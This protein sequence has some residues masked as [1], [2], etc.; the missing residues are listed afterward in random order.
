MGLEL[1]GKEIELRRAALDQQDLGGPA[2]GG[3]PEPGQAQDAHRQVVGRHPEGRGPDHR[4]LQEGLAQVRG[5]AGGR[6]RGDE[7]AL[8]PPRLDVSTSL[9]IVDDARDGIR[10]DAEEAG[11][12]ADAG[13]RL[14]PRD[15][16]GLDGMAELLSQLTP[17]RDRTVPIY[18][19]VHRAHRAPHT[20]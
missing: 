15:A 19:E 5:G 1:A 3:G 6:R 20:V 18:R 10:I 8:P 13:Q 7:H 11:E 14:V 16:T 9:Q 2:N 17:D 12:L 4:I